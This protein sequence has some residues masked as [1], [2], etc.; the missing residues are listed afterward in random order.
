VHDRYKSLGQVEQAFRRSKTVELE[1]RPVHVRKEESTR[2][3][4]L[5]CMLD[6]LLLK[7]LGHRW[8]PLDLT[9]E[10]GLKRLNTS[11][12]VEVAGV[13]EVMLEPRED[14]QSLLETAGVKLPVAVARSPSRVATRKKL[15]KRRPTRLQ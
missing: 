3:H 1:M 11:C 8:A 2:G 10:E 14:V 13:I 9:M 6:Y 15:P 5:A 12:A 4:L 7:E